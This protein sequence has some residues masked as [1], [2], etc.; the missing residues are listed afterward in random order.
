MPIF[1]IAEDARMSALEERSNRLLRLA[2]KNFERAECAATP[3]L[4]AQFRATGCQYRDTAIL[5]LERAAPYSAA[6]ATK[7][8]RP[9]G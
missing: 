6:I 7:A 2:I 8:S 4:A 1:T 9:E 5:M 3:A